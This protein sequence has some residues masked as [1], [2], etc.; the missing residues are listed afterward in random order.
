MQL[1]KPTLILGTK[2]TVDRKRLGLENNCTARSYHHHPSF[3]A[4]CIW[5]GCLP[6][7]REKVL[8]KIEKLLRAP[9]L[10]FKTPGDMTEQKNRPPVN[11]ICNIGYISN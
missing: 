1:D 7:A 3:K 2:I 6:L 8:L 5:G 11:W 4:F 9:C 10:A